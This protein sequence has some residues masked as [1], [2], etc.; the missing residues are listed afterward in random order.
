[1]AASGSA[2]RVAV[3]VMTATGV[4][5]FSLNYGSLSAPCNSSRG[6]CTGSECYDQAK[7]RA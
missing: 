3:A 1:M 2:T 6:D 5:G 4:S 7:A